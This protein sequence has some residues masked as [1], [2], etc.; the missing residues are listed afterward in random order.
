MYHILLILPHI[1]AT[2]A[3]LLITW[4]LGWNVGVVEGL[5]L[6]G[7]TFSSAFCSDILELITF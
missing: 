3:E 4:H 6:S 2:V 5:N 7:N 1:W